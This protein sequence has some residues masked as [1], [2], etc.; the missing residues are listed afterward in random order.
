MTLNYAEI[1]PKWQKAWAD[2]KVYESEPD[3]RKGMLVTAAFPYVN[4]PLHIGHLR[5]YG[6][7]RLL[8]EVQAP[9]GLQRPLP[10]GIPRHRHPDTRDREEDSQQGRRS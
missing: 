1:E 2:A 4:T 10:N 3:E 5:T 7:S 6:D 9:Q 8:C